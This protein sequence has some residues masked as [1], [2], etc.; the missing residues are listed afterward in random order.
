VRA[1]A[2]LLFLNLASC[3]A[4]RP[5]AISIADPALDVERTPDSEAVL[6]LQKHLEGPTPSLRSIIMV[7]GVTWDRVI[8]IGADLGSDGGK[9]SLFGKPEYGLYANPIP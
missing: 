1:V 2:A 7:D 5:R 9:G 3:A 8:Q 6:S 4:P